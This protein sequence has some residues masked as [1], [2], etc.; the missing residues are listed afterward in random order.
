MT[1]AT[2]RLASATGDSTL[3]RAFTSVSSTWAAIWMYGELPHW[4]VPSA[5][6]GQ[7]SGSTVTAQAGSSGVVM[8]TIAA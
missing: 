3:V 1:S 8:C 6:R 5:V 4:Y 7:A 2:L